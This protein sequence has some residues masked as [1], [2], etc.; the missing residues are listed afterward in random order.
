[1]FQGFTLD[2]VDV[3]EVVL[4]VRH[5]GQ[6]PPV[7]LLHGHPR[8]HATWHR[9][10][11]RLARRTPSSARICAGTARST[12][13]P[14]QPD[15]RQSSKRAM[16]GDVVA[17][18]RML[19]HD[20]FAVVGHDRGALVALRAALDHPDAVDASRDHGRP[21]DRGAPRAAQ[22]DF[23]RTWWHWWFLAK[24]T[25]RPSASSARIP[26]AWYRT[27]PA[28]IMGADATPTSGRRCD[29]PAVVHGMCEDYRAGLRIDR[30]TRRTIEPRA[31]ASHARCCSC[32]PRTTTSTSMAIR[33]PSGDRGSAAASPAAVID[34]GHHQAEEQPGQVADALLNFLADG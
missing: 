4:R 8:T 33:W 15:H 10:A 16:A 26:D 32:R 1:M 2:E 12:L 3:G 11:P 34:S 25:S 9:V 21:A 5:G 7:V 31:D 19:G 20:R 14:D 30:T 22:R 23:V 6:G 24:P 18:M 29:D 17:L 13:P 27:P 28:E